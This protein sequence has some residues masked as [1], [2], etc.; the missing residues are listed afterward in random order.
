MLTSNSLKQ[1]CCVKKAQIQSPHYN[2]QH[3]TCVLHQIWPVH[4]L[5]HSNSNICL[6]MI[7]IKW[8]CLFLIF[9]NVTCVGNCICVNEKLRLEFHIKGKELNLCRSRI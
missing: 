6:H 8:F 2:A 9:L 7:A 1:K 5:F 3:A 4:K